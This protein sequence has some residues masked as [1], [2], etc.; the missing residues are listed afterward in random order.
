M[1]AVNASIITSS[2]QT[3]LA[4]QSVSNT[5]TIRLVSNSLASSFIGNSLPRFFPMKKRVV[6]IS[7]EV[8]AAAAVTTSPVEETK[9]FTLPSRA[10]FELG[11][12]PVYWKT[13][14]GLPPSSGEKL[15]LFYNPTA[16]NLVPN[17]E[18]RIAFN[19]SIHGLPTILLLRHCGI[20]SAAGLAYALKLFS[21]SSFQL[22]F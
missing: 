14:N 15:R 10:M 21:Y 19:G 5:N 3:F 6:K 7:G 2:T 8:R 4:M 22:A 18:F 11:K 1:A 13:M 16:N 9:E 12:A 17:E 20:R